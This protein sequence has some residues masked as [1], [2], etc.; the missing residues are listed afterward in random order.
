V[1]TYVKLEG[2]NYDRVHSALI[3]GDFFVTPPRVILDLEAALKGVQIDAIEI[4][5]EKFFQESRIDTL[6]VSP[7]DFYAS[8]NS[9]LQRR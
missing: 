9:A 4:T 2:T 7:A 3:T 1:T 5:I 6:T 8:I